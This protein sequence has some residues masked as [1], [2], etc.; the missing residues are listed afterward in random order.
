MILC[1]VLSFNTCN[2]NS[3]FVHDYLAHYALHFYR[4]MKLTEKD[5]ILG[6]DITT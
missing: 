2:N 6:R 4:N 3:Q 1:P 5:K